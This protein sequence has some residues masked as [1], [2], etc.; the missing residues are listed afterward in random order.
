MNIGDRNAEPDESICVSEKNKSIYWNINCDFEYCVI[1]WG[2][3][4]D[5]RQ[6]SEKYLKRVTENYSWQKNVQVAIDGLNE[7][8]DSG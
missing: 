8:I 3:E 7:G 5:E 6:K 4:V 2:K 1:E